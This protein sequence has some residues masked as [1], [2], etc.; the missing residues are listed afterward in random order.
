MVRVSPCSHYTNLSIWCFQGMAEI[1]DCWVAV[2]SSHKLAGDAVL[3]CGRDIKRDELS[4]MRQTSEL[5]W[6]CNSI[7]FKGVE[8]VIASQVEQC[9]VP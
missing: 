6:Q 5:C 8:F 4:K 9:C 2:L 1:W 3:Q 7:T